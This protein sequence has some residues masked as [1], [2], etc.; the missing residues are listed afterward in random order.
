MY[1]RKDK[2]E[3]PQVISQIVNFDS[4]FFS[5]KYVKYMVTLQEMSQRHIWLLTKWYK[6]CAVK[7]QVKSMWDGL[8]SFQ[9][10]EGHEMVCNM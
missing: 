2:K 8:G 7:G 6:Y 5:E 1:T 3:D 10:R 9:R 4:V